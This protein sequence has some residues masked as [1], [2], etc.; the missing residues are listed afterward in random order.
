MV[1]NAD[2]VAHAAN[3]AIRGHIDLVRDQRQKP[4]D[5]YEQAERRRNLVGAETTRCLKVGAPAEID[6]RPGQDRV[7]G[8]REDRDQRAEQDPPCIPGI[9]EAGNHMSERRRTERESDQAQ[10]SHGDQA[11]CLSW[12]KVDHGDDD[13]GQQHE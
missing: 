10:F 1:R 7:G 2:Q 4:E 8:D 13:T 5:E 12:R 3:P 9:I 11:P 6:V